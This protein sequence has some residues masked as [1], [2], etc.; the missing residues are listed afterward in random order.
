MK[1]E[2][3]LDE[4]TI[5]RYAKHL[6]YDDISADNVNENEMFKATLADV[7]ECAIDSVI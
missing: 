7:M 5:L 4:T 6:G 1:V 2:L 3:N